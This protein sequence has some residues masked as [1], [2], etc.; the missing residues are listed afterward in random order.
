[1]RKTVEVA[2]LMLLGILYWITYAALNGANR[3]PLRIPTHFDISG[4]PN[5]WGS[6]QMLW[7]LPLIGTGVYLLLTAL[8][9][10]RFRRYNLPV[11]VTEAN[12]P[13]MQSKTGEMLAWIKFEVLLLFT[14]IQWGII[15]GARAGEFHLSPAIVPA[16]L[17][18]VFATVGC[19][20]AM[21]VRGAKVRA[22][23]RD[24]VDKV[25]N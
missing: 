2:G 18:T 17:V 4:R 6:P 22:E 11:R 9:T 3:L 21:M 16:F 20:L 13:F 12:L 8:G 24:P 15:Q 19:Y 23:S 5:A 14:C 10:I 25:Q 1:M 7:L